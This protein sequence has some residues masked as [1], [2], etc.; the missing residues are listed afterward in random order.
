[1]QAWEMY[2]ADNLPRLVD[3]ML[4]GNFSETE[5][6]GF[7]EGCPALCAREVSA[8]TEYVEGNQDDER[9]NRHPQ[10]TDHTARIHRRYHGCENR[11]KITELST[12]HH[13][14]VHHKQVQP[15]AV[16]SVICVRIMDFVLCRSKKSLDGYGDRKCFLCRSNPP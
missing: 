5:A 6:V 15:K 10:H 8:S 14:Q 2:E 4:D 16:P 11:T 3:P 12:R 13:K 1:M 7:R 9:G